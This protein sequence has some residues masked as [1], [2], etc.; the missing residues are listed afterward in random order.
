MI[1]MIKKR[2]DMMKNWKQ[3]SKL[4]LLR[5]INNGRKKTGKESRATCCLRTKKIRT[6]RGTK[7]ESLNE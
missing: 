5:M 6:R 3:Q 2:C 1:L 4:V 7:E